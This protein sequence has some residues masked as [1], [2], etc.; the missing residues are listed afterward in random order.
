MFRTKKR[1][2]SALVLAVVGVLV[3]VAA[4]RNEPEAAAPVEPPLSPTKV[5]VARTSLEPM[6][7]PIR[8]TGEIRPL[9]QA[10]VRAESGGRVLEMALRLG[11]AVESGQR[12][13][14]LDGSKNALAIRQARARVEQAEIMLDQAS[15][16]RARS[17]I[18]FASQKISEEQY[19]D[20]V[21]GQREAE[22][23]LEL[24]RAEHDSLVRLD[25]DF[26]IRAPYDA[27]V[28]E[29][30]IQVGDFVTPGALAFSIVE[31][32]GVKASFKVPA[33][34]MAAFAQTER[35][36][37]EVPALSRSFDAPVAA[38]ARQ[39]DARSRTFEVELDLPRDADLRAGMIARLATRLET[40]REGLFVPGSAV[41]EKFGGSFIYVVREGRAHQ[42]PVE[43]E[44]RSGERV[45]VS[46]ALGA[47]T[48][49]IVSGQHRLVDG[50]P[51]QATSEALAVRATSRL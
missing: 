17:E 18:L 38:I 40:G 31:R 25:Q 37:I 9:R 46:G 33:D 50:G 41:V 11:D 7:D 28:T 49:V 16:K 36:R 2:T 3:G 32:G 4:T 39:A 30:G 5:V 10:Q 47:G 8:L 20:A 34:H 13:A 19:D 6:E 43:I 21:F 24:R 22:A 35:H 12:L 23:M 26:E 51:V 45:A 27:Y 44:R 42:I 48:P 1:A 15:R 14:Q 29:I